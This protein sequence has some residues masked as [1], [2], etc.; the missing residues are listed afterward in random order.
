M[1]KILFAA[2]AAVAF[3]G[4]PIGSACAGSISTV[5]SDNSTDTWAGDLNWLGLPS[6]T[7]ILQQYASYSKSNQYIA[8]PT[9]PSNGANVFSKL[10]G[11]MTPIPS[12]LEYYTTTS[13][14]SYYT[15]FWGQ[16]LVLEGAVRY[17][18]ANTVNVGNLAVPV[19]GLGPQT[20][21]PNIWDNPEFSFGLGYGIIADRRAE[22]FL[23]VKSYFY[24][25]SNFNNLN[26]FNVDPPRMFTWVPQLGYSEG[27]TKFGLTN[28][29]ID[30]IGNVSVHG[31]GDSPLALAPGVQFDT[32]T[33]STSY[34]F[35]AF[36]RYADMQRA[37]I[38]AGI[39]RSWGGNQ[40]A[41]GGLLETIFGGPTSFGTDDFTK[42][43]LQFGAALP[44]DMQLA[45][46]VTHDFEREGGFKEEFGI[47]F[48]LT[49]F[50][51]PPQPPPPLSTNFPTK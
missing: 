13:R 41:S 23:E 39:E 16:P 14:A 46:D 29:W 45:A 28:M 44:Y 18:K 26:Q 30:L 21:D 8:T 43:H 4:V 1:K 35:K 40:I 32:L 12:T 38:A 48:R 9:T 51:V 17:E 10:T 3:C 49:K 36:V 34:D 37:Y 20:M 25:P 2:T 42:G 11:G 7:L 22:R 27:L 19:G 15:S 47:E 5:G 33:Q 6:G 24:L 31:P 50:F